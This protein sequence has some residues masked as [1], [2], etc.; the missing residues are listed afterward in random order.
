MQ[1][2]TGE[3]LASD[4]GYQFA[5]GQGEQALDRAARAR[6]GF[7]SGAA[8]KD[9]LRFNE[10][11][12]SQRF[13]EA[14]NR[15]QINKTN[16]FNWLSGLSGTGQTTASQIGSFGANNAN[17]VGNLVT[18]AGNARAAGIV[19]G[20]NAVNNTIGNIANNWAQQSML[21]QI[22]GRA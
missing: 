18:G 20:A 22:L 8:V 4:P 7:D 1:Q 19:G 12:A 16:T 11:L 13:N 14:F 9:L 15:D 2:F 10:G 3:N 5:L 21:S 17:T 6:G